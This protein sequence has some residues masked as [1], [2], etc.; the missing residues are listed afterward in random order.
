MTSSIIIGSEIKK[1]RNEKGLT[2]EE[3]AFK[4]GVS[5]RTIQRIE[6]GEVDAR[7]Y[8]LSQ[9]AEA[10]EVTLD[11]FSVSIPEMERLKQERIRSNRKWL[12]LLHFSG[13]FALL[14]PPVIIYI[15]KRDE[16]PHMKSHGRDVLNFQ[17]TLWLA[18]FLFAISPVLIIGIFVLPLIGIFSTAYVLINTVRVMNDSPYHYPLTINFIKTPEVD[19]DQGI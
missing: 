16:I 18:L 9:I 1:L 7:N 6:S 12:S 11:H 14:I 8:T 4:C 13:L 19:L 10:L 15:L 5:T 17:L 2:Q 3:L